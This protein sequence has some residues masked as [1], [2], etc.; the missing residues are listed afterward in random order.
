ML[1][2]RVCIE[3]NHLQTM[4]AHNVDDLEIAVFTIRPYRE[5]L[6]LEFDHLETDMH[7]VTL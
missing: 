2:D 6:R 7:C 4:C 5:I 3:L 1:K